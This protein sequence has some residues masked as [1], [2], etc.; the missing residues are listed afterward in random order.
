[1]IVV[2]IIMVSKFCHKSNHLV[3]GRILVDYIEPSVLLVLNLAT[4][5]GRKA[6]STF[7]EFEPR[8]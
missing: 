8:A 1:M 4:V 3:E 2:V 6:K 5:K 7:E